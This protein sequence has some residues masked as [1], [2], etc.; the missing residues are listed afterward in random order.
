M[1]QPASERRRA[2]CPREPC[3]NPGPVRRTPM[4]RGEL[5]SH[6][7]PSGSAGIV[8]KKRFGRPAAGSSPPALRHRSQT[9]DGWNGIKNASSPSPGFSRTGLIALGVSQLSKKLPLHRSR[10]E[11]A[12]AMNGW[13]GPRKND[14]SEESP[15]PRRRGRPASED[16]SESMI[17]AHGV[18]VPPPHTP[19]QT[20][21]CERG[22]KSRNESGATVTANINDESDRG[23]RCL[24]EH[25][26]LSLAPRTKEPVENPA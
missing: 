19:Q 2:A 17:F 14:K 5:A 16:E 10:A 26:K 20:S 25:E 24:S 18:I 6:I 13:T 1:Q 21:L 4:A 9:S 22:M 15:P 11:R 8:A 3:G 23:T 12:D 7:F